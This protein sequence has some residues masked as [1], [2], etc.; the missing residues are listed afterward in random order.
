[1]RTQAVLLL[2]AG[3]AAAFAACTVAPPVT[4][5]RGSELATQ[6][7][8][9]GDPVKMKRPEL[10]PFDG[11]TP[12]FHVIKSEEQ[13]NGLWRVPGTQ[14]LPQGFDPSATMLLVA[15]AGEEDVMQTRIHKVLETA[16]AVHVYVR[17]TKRGALCANHPDHTP[18]DA[19]AVTRI[20]KPVRFYVEEESAESC[21]ELPA[22][23]VKC[24]AGDAPTWTSMLTAEPGETV[25]CELSAEAKG[26]FALVDR[27][28]TLP[29]LPGGS[30]AKLA[31]S[32]APTRGSFVVDVF[33]TYLVRGE[34]TDEGGRTS[35]GVAT[36]DA[37]PPATKDVFVQLVWTNFDP[38]DDPETF[39]RVR[40]KA[41]EDALRGR[42]CGVDAPVIGVCDVRAKSAFSLMKLKSTAGRMGLFV[43]YV[44]ERV[45]KGPLVCVQVWAGGKR[46]SETCDRVHRDAGAR[47]D[48][49]IVDTATGALVD[50]GQQADAGADAAPPIATDAGATR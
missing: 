18:A 17:E 12:G 20:E 29:S 2:A 31:Y 13:L 48:V 37:A 25:D 39:P 40:L 15:V 27:V 42:E 24:R 6:P 21:G 4:V 14:K 44:D 9:V 32:K 16:A 46:T 35:R 30:A 36:I 3:F 33:G 28:M 47:W 19:V 1:M 38:T 49:G 34:A 23:S 41:R 5:Y 26:R 45:E 11:A 10:A 8:V 43:N 50:L 22:V 7:A